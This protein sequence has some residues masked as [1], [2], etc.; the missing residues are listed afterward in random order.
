M[1]ILQATMLTPSDTMKQ[2][3]TSVSIRTAAKAFLED[4][5]G[6]PLLP[7]WNRV[8]SALPNFLQQLNEAIRLDNQ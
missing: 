8:Q 3:R 2:N 5:L 6:A 1:A 7:N 4:P